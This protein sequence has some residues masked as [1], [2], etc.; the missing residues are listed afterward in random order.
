MGKCGID[1]E[2][3]NGLVQFQ[4]LLKGFGLCE[5]ILT[6]ELFMDFA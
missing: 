5:L 4:S 1:I 2:G 6:I 3:C